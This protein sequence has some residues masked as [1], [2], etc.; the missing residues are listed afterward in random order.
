KLHAT[1]IPTRGITYTRSDGTPWKLTVAD[2]LAR[3]ANLEVAYN[4]NDCV[5]VRWGATEGTPEYTPCTRH[6]PP[7][8]KSKMADARPW[9]HD[10]KRPPR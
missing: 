7:D 5:E 6:A 2:L 8:Q 10:A 3:R 4:P 1:L 9:F